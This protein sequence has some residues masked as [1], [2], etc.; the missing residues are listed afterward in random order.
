MVTYDFYENTYLGTAVPRKVF[1]RYAAQA[2][3]VLDRLC[4]IC[5]VEGGEESRAMAVCAMA[6][7]LYR[8]DRYGGV[9]TASAGEVSVRY[10]QSGGLMAELYAQAGIYL[11]IY[12]GVG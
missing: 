7:T 8:H 3:S 4:G 6:E 12:R 10:R 2:Q 9:E 11:D 5:R 1:P